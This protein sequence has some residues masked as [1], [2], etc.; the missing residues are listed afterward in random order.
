MKIILII[1][2]SIMVLGFL[3]IFFSATSKSKVYTFQTEC[4]GTPLRLEVY[5]Q[6]KYASSYHFMLITYGNLKPIRL[7]TDDITGSWFPWRKDLY[8]TAPFYQWDTTR[9]VVPEENSSFADNLSWPYFIYIDPQQ[10]TKQD[11]ESLATC[12]KEKNTELQTALYKDFIRPAHHLN[13]PQLVGIVYGR[14]DNFVWE[15]KKDNLICLIQPNKRI[16]IKKANDQENMLVFG[17]LTSENNIQFLKTELT[18]LAPVT[19][20]DFVNTK[21]GNKLTEDFTVEIVEELDY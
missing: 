3:I 11:F 20:A 7:T 1:I 8:Q 9:Q 15:Y 17:L 21:T 10:Y 19:I 13:Y 16:E 4:S 14:R 18:I 12:L 2:A 6:N 5:N